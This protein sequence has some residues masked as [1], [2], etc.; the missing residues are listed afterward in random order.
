MRGDLVMPVSFWEAET[1]SNTAPKL[2]P[3][4]LDVDEPNRGELH[5]GR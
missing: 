5:D 4:V 3:A 1:Q 2:R